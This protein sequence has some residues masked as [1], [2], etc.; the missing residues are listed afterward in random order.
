ME[1]P[2]P[3]SIASGEVA[4][5]DDEEAEREPDKDH[6]HPWIIIERAA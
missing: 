2:S 5:R 4:S 1:P 6:I 3:E